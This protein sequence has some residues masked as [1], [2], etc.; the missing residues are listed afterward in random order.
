MEQIKPLLVM[1][2]Y[3][4]EK[5]KRYRLSKE[6]KSKADKNRQRVEEAFLKSTHVARAEAAAA[7]REERKRLEKEKV[8]AEDDPEKQRKWEAKEEKKQAKKRAP[9]MRQLKVKAL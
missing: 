5:V 4:I 2:F 6:A 9:R 7:R 1:V 8:M 3:C